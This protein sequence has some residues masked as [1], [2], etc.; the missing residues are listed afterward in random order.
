LVFKLLEHLLMLDCL[1]F[2][3]LVSFKQS[4]NMCDGLSVDEVIHSTGE[5]REVGQAVADTIADDLVSFLDNL[6]IR[7]EIIVNA[8]A[9]R[10]SLNVVKRIIRNWHTPLTSEGSWSAMVLVFLPHLGLVS[11]Q[12]GEETWSL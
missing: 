4:T 6:L 10:R 11:I 1:L 8:A 12:G 2:R 5:G 7:D 9:R 3:C